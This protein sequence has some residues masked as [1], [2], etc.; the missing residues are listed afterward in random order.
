MLPFFGSMAIVIA[1][2]TSPSV[3]EAAGTVQAAPAPAPLVAAAPSR[4][5]RFD[6]QTV[7]VVRSDTSAADRAI[8]QQTQ[9]RVLMPALT[10]DGGG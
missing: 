6:Q 10:G 5:L 9:L 8:Q 7:S 1:A 2:A 4:P 3:P